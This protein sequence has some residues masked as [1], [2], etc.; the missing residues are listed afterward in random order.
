MEA[1][2]EKP[3]RRVLTREEFDEDQRIQRECY[4]KL[5]KY[6]DFKKIEPLMYFDIMSYEDYLVKYQ[7]L[8]K[9][10]GE[11]SPPPSPTASGIDGITVEEK[12]YSH[13]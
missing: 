9:A 8:Y 3:Q 1:K 7:K 6:D 12:K 4:D 5:S 11:E 2:Q 13:R 10:P